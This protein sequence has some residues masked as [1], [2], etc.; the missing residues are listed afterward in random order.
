MAVQVTTASEVEGEFDVREQLDVGR[1]LRAVGLAAKSIGFPAKE[2]A[3]IALVASELATNLVKHGGGGKL[4]FGEEVRSGQRG[5]R[6]EAL[7]DGGGIAEIERAQ[8]DGFSTR[9]GLGIGLGAVNRLTD[10]L[11]IVSGIGR[12]TRV[13]CRKWLQ[14]V[15]VVNNAQ[16]WQIGVAS[17]PKLLQNGDDTVMK[18]WDDDFLV[19]VIDGVGHGALAHQA[20]RASRL[21]VE[22]HFD[23]PMAMIFQGVERLCRGTRGVVMA[24]ARFR[25]AASEL[26]FASVGNIEARLLC[27]DAPFKDVVR[28]GILGLRAPQPDVV[29]CAWTCADALVIHSDG[30]DARWS[31]AGLHELVRL[32]P[33][34]IAQEVLARHGKLTDDATVLV[35]ARRRS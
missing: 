17:R 6:I 28:R 16:R 35:V 5:L 1:A 29:K 30:V 8:Q 15:R 10:E 34:V 11:E 32:D 24:L 22:G 26:E 9:G 19:G 3:E 13:I 20:A 18:I 7:D 2:C 12:G 31:L 21:Y 14:N 27:G 25:K 4:L 23:Q 33:T